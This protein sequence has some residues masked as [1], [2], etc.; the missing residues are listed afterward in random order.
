MQMSDLYTAANDKFIQNV[1]SNDPARIKQANEALGDYVKVQLREDCF[2]DKILNPETITDADLDRQ[3][4][5]DKPLKIVDKE[6]GSP[7]AISVPFGQLPINEYIRGPKYAIMFDRIVTPRFTKDI[8]ELRTYRMDIRQ[9]V[10]DNA[11]K[12]LSAEKDGKFMQAVNSLLGTQDVAV[13][14]TG[15]VQWKGI[16]GG[17]TRDTLVE[18]KKIMPSTPSRLRPTIALCN[19]I[20][21]LE[22]EKFGRDEMGGDLSEE[23]FRNGWAIADFMGMRWIITIKSDLVPDNNIYF[24]ASQDFLGRS[25]V[26]NDITMWI[27]RKHY[28]L[29]FFAYGTFG[30]GIGNV[31]GVA[32]ATFT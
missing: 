3:V 23:V 25:Y 7:A 16:A 26:L 32:R 1:M 4:W 30:A 2:S 14:A 24:F 11:V 31:A 6:P 28:L 19:Q 9:V 13:A 18:A 29:E 21:A 22:L 15:V 27:E 12:D 8:D 10:S 20:T 5:T 17:I